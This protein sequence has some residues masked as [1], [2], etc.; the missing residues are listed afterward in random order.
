[1]ISKSDLL[2]IFG[3]ISLVIAIGS[4]TYNIDSSSFLTYAIIFFT[5]AIVVGAIEAKK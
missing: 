1:M 3:G 5:G 2:T 4:V